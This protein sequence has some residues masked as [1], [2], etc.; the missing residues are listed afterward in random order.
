MVER[1]D[2]REATALVNGRIVL[3]GRLVEGRSVMVAGGIVLDVVE[4]DALGGDVARVDVGGR[5]I[6]PGLIDIHIHGANN[7]TFN[8]P[9]AEGYDA[10]LSACVARGVTSVLATL[11]T[12]PIPSLVEGMRFAAEWTS[13]S[14]RSAQVLGVHLEGPYFSQEQRGAQDPRHI[15]TPDDGTVDALLEHHGVMRMMS[16]APELLG[17]L[18]LTARLAALGVVPAAG[19][20]S[21][22][23]TDV[24]L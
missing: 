2:S 23:D 22:M 11:A 18:E 14:H 20:S 10:I 16:F 15:R 24:E 9:S 19:H 13:A 3:P 6:A 21:A 17:A 8:E 12:A 4:P 1:T 7:H 5:Y